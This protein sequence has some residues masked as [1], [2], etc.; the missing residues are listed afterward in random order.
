[1]FANELLVCLDYIKILISNGLLNIFTKCHKPLP[2]QAQ[3]TLFVAL[4][5]FWNL[6]SVGLAILSLLRAQVHAVQEKNLSGVGSNPDGMVGCK[7]SAS[8]F[9]TMFSSLQACGNKLFTSWQM[10]EET[11]FEIPAAKKTRDSDPVLIAP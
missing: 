3:Q 8:L 2:E 6:C 4:I 1:L 5:K 7:Y 9:T 11:M 10:Q